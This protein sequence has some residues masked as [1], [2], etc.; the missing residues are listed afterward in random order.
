MEQRG[1]GKELRIGMERKRTEKR[2][3][4]KEVGNCK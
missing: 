2:D 1:I 3:R 4:T